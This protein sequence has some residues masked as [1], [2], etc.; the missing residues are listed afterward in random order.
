MFLQK[1]YTEMYPE[2]TAAIIGAIIGSSISVA[3][4]VY[5]IKYKQDLQENKQR[6]LFTIAILDDLKNAILLYEKIQEELSKSS[7]VWF[8]TLQELRKSRQIAEKHNDLVILFKSS[9]LRQKIK[10]YYLKSDHIIS[11][12]ENY[13][14]RKHILE[15]Q[16]KQLVKELKMQGALSEEAANKKAHELMDS[17]NQEL[18]LINF[19]IQKNVNKLDWFTNEAQYLID[20]I[21][22]INN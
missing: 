16:F 13:Q 22:E 4:A 18:I 21:Y 10:K 15:N 11:T 20:K 8:I 6:E 12:L 9:E 2:I 19:E 5:L 1:E 17:E 7:L 3:A 14:N